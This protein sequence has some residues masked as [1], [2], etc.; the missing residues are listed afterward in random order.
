MTPVNQENPGA[1]LLRDSW[2][3]CVS[4][5][6]LTRAQLVNLSGDPAEPRGVDGLDADADL[7]GCRH[8]LAAI[9]PIRSEA[10]RRWERVEALEA[11]RD[12]VLIELEPKAAR[13]SGHRRSR[14]E[15][16]EQLNLV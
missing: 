3:G 10:T 5:S 9:A 8:F 12:R 1:S 15:P 2:V 13:P 16:A 4:S 6:P 7:S 14:P 11:V